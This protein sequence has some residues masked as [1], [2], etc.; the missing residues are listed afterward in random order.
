MPADT[1]LPL[2][3]TVRV[4]P[5]GGRDAVDGWDTDAAGRTLLK[6]RVA[7]PPED[8]KANRAVERLLAKV[9]KVPHSAVRVASGET[10][11]VKTIELSARPAAANAL[12]AEIDRLGRP[13]MEG[14]R[15]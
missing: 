11:R 6:L 10:S 1:A 7:V 15:G 12:M 5:R 14:G 9:L 2:R 13:V 8:G 4:T 3:F